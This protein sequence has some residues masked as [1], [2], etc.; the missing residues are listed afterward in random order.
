MA[1]RGARRGTVSTLS[2]TVF[3]MLLMIGM[4]VIICMPRYCPRVFSDTEDRPF[5]ALAALHVRCVNT[6]S[7]G[8]HRRVC[9]CVCVCGSEGVRDGAREVFECVRDGVSEGRSEWVSWRQQ[10]RR[11]ERENASARV[12]LDDRGNAFLR[13]VGR[14]LTR[15]H[16]VST[17]QKIPKICPVLIVG[18]LGAVSAAMLPHF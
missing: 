17:C 18:R 15:E 14:C 1:T 10:E 7:A 16:A 5:R 3:Q 2:T 12:C 8:P 9:V 11:S 6:A 4:E 13:D